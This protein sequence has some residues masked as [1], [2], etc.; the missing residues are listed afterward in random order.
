[1]ADL[2]LKPDEFRHVH[3]KPLYS[4]RVL[5]ICVLGFAFFTG[6]GVFAA[7]HLNAPW[8]GLIPVPCAIMLGVCLAGLFPRFFFTRDPR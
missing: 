8:A 5:W 7:G 6:L 2:E 3:S 4:A 1:M